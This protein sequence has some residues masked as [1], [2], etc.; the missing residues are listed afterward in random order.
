MTH[1]PHYQL[2]ARLD[3]HR[4]ALLGLLIAFPVNAPPAALAAGFGVSDVAGEFDDDRRTILRSIDDVLDTIGDKLDRYTAGDAMRWI[5][6]VAAVRLD[7]P[8]PSGE[9]LPSVNRLLGCVRRAWD[10]TGEFRPDRKVS[11]V[12]AVAR[13]LDSIRRLRQTQRQVGLDLERARR[14]RLDAARVAADAT[15][16]LEAA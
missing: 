1:D 8:C 15:R 12:E 16:Q 5:I 4:D 6:A 10:L 14:A 9:F 2:A 7:G 11:V 3:E 13:Q